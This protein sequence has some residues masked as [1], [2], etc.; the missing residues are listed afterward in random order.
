MKKIIIWA[1][2]VLIICGLALP[3]EATTPIKLY[4]NGQLAKIDGLLINNRTYVPARFVSETLGASVNYVDGVVKISTKTGTATTIPSAELPLKKTG[5]K[6]TIG[7]ISYTVDAI[8]YQTRG[9]TRYASITFIEESKS[10]IG[11]F[12]LLPDFEIQQ[13]TKVT[14]LT[15]YTVTA[16]ASKPSDNTQY[17]RTF[18]YTFPWEGE[19]S[20]VYYY[21]QGFGEAVKPIGRWHR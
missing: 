15:D 13:G 21:P 2:A 17:R 10:S 5:E 14:P 4:I 16:K 7:D 3:G 9:S 8:T 18:T 19:I 1:L 11:E 12:G 6:V 20:Y